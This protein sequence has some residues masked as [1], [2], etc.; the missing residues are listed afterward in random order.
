MWPTC[1]ESRFP[2]ASH[3]VRFFFRLRGGS[4]A[5]SGSISF[6]TVTLHPTSGDSAG[7]SVRM[8]TVRLT[9]LLPTNGY[10][11]LYVLSLFFASLILTFAGAFLTLD[12]TR[13]FAPAGDAYQD[14]QKSTHRL[15]ASFFRGGVGGILTGFIFGC[16]SLFA[17]NPAEASLSQFISPPS[18]PPSYQ[19]SLH[20]NPWNHLLSC[21]FGCS[22]RWLHPS[23]REDGNILPSLFQD[24]VGGTFTVR[25][26]LIHLRSF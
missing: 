3:P 10:F 22:H 24:S 12:R 11:L 25:D 23:L 4:D 18:Y 6:R 19:A 1:E 20:P 9:D 17:S 8:A 14:R 26:N 21:L 16:K 13:S 2:L 5:I 15:V 7:G